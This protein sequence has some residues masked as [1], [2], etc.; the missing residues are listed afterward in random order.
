MRSAAVTIGL[1]ALR[2]AGL[3][4]QAKAWVE[5]K[6]PCDIKPGFFRLNSAIVDLQHA[7]QQP[8][9]RDHLLGQAQDVLV[10]TI[11]DDKQD[12][13]PAAWY[14]LGRYYVEQGDAVGADTAFARAAA[15]APQCKADI[16]SYTAPLAQATLNQG[17]TLWQA[18]N[19][20]SGAIL[21]RRAYAAD[22]TQVKALFQLGLLYIDSNQLD[23]ASA[24][25]RRAAQIAAGDTAY[26]EARRD[27]LLT[28][29]RM[30]MR[31]VQSD[32]AVQ[33]WQHTRYSR[34]SLAPYLASDS[35]VL[36]RMQASSA[37][38]RARGARLSPTDQ[39]SFSHDSAARADAVS[40]DRAVRDA[41]QP[42]A[43]TDSTAAQVVF[44]PAIASY[45][46]LVAAYPSNA[47]AAG[48]LASI[49]VQAGR[50]SEAITVFD[51][52]FA[53]AGDLSASDLY[54]LG[55]R[56]VS[57]RLWAPGIKAYALALERNPYHRN[58]LSELGS[59]YVETKD[60]TNAV[61]T[62]QRLVVLD[63]MNRMALHLMGQAWDLRGQTDSARK[64][65]V[66]SDSLSVDITIASMVP[67]SSGITLTGVATNA[68]SAAAKTMHLTVDFL[69]AKGTVLATQGVDIPAVPA[70]GSQQFQ[71]H[72]AAKGAVG[73]RYRAA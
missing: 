51:G 16:A 55:Q 28:V 1:L 60:G 49:Y 7:V 43:A 69:D 68:G 62:L 70:G 41:T 35:S 63:P 19:K 2:A 73:W 20:D 72:A 39:Q 14:Y 59:A 61:A 22:S 12:K 10:R 21:L 27:A 45:Q 47:E 13:N 8:Q 32:P 67:D 25:L 65:T 6:P 26:S 18:G 29:A 64:Y 44:Q 46:E 15:L 40:R 58:A 33:K 54:D 23:S 9:M 66:A 53:H 56:L 48:S 11:R 52:L 42:Q 3:G 31:A 30:S 5:P 24:V 37:S 17:L 71:A 4:A 34:D 57:S 50:R 38:R 36:A